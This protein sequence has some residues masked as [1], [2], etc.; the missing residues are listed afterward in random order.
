MQTD[1]KDDLTLKI[2]DFGFA[3][4][5]NKEELLTEILGSPLYMA[6]EIV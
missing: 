5:F 4:M 3:K 6:P 2:T 1:K